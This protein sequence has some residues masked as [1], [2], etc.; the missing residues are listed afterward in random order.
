MPNLEF[1]LED[2]VDDLMLLYN[3]LALELCRH[4]IKAIHTTASAGDVLNLF[5][6]VS[7]RHVNT[8]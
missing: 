2:L 7:V 4:D 1:L 3:A 6:H 8:N 5:G